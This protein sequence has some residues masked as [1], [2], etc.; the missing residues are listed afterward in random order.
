MS[1]HNLL[2]LN[3]PNVMDELL[4]PSHK[5]VKIYDIKQK[6]HGCHFLPPN[7][8]NALKKYSDEQVRDFNAI[9]H[10]DKSSYFRN[11]RIKRCK[12]CL[13]NKPNLKRKNQNLIYTSAKTEQL[14]GKF[15]GK[16]LEHLRDK[17]AIQAF[18][19]TQTTLEFLLKELQWNSIDNQGANIISSVHYGKKYDN[20][21]W[22]GKQMVYGD[23]DGIVFRSFTSSQDV[24]S[25]EIFHGVTQHG[26]NLEY[27]QQAGALNESISDVF[28]TMI[29][30]WA[31]HETVE[32][33]DWLIGNELLLVNVGG[34]GAL[35]SLKFPGEAY[36]N[37][38][39]L[40]K[41]PQ[42]WRMGDYQKLSDRD[43]NG[44]V[45][46]N[47]GIPNK[48]FYEACEKIGGYSWEKMGKIWFE[49]LKQSK[50][51]TQFQEFANLTI[52]VASQRFGK[53][54]AE[55]GAVRNAWKTTEV[56]L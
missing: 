13:I 6:V 53:D 10:V 38:S 39:V 26:P 44:G 20:A 40:G 52:A 35:R 2:T 9:Y 36:N 23:G 7:V 50:S 5:P 25:H 4:N 12:K 21:F 46:I 1:I 37:E 16:S 29:T 31:N 32:T 8:E 45:H 54:S 34:L 14:P 15:L 11:K 41:D 19:G 51:N 48:A 55:E 47:S 22:E 28:A 43:D 42:V 56:L 49:A 3:A 33:A 24:I 30:Q 27:S 18:Q 17:S